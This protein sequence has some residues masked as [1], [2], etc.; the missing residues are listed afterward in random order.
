MNQIFQEL[1][2]YFNIRYGKFKLK[3]LPKLDIDYLKIP[4]I[5]DKKGNKKSDIC[6]TDQCRAELKKDALELTPTSIKLNDFATLY[7][8]LDRSF[9]NNKVS[10]FIDVGIPLDLSNSRE[11]SALKLYAYSIEEKIQKIEPIT[12]TETTK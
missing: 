6:K 11:I 4:I 7:H 12:I 1:E 3:Q 10:V 8:K 2:K 9:I 5:H